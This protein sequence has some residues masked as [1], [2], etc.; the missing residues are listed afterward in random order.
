MFKK[1]SESLLRNAWAHLSRDSPIPAQQLPEKTS[2][3]WHMKLSN[4]RGLSTTTQEPVTIG[5]MAAVMF[6]PSVVCGYLA[7]WQYERMEWKES[8]IKVRSDSLQNEARNIFN[9]GDPKEYEKVS[10]CGVF[11]H[12]KSVFVGPRP[13]NVPGIGIQ[14]GYLLITPLYD[15]KRKGAILVNRGWVPRSWEKD[16]RLL[17][18]S[19]KG[20]AEIVGVVQP[21][22]KPSAVVPDNV[23]EKGEFHWLDVPN[24][25]RA[26]GLP[27]D[28]PLV[29]AVSNDP[30]TVQQMKRQSPLEESRDRPL[31]DNTTPTFPIP[32]NA[33]DLVRFST[34]PSDHMMYAATWAM[35][36]VGLG[37]MARQVVFYPRKYRKMIGHTNKEHWKSVSTSD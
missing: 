3:L 22:E 11:L 14:S 37:V 31:A 2:R 30:A 27:L 5:P 1:L 8:L 34:M 16:I 32:K 9:H 36:C 20:E 13:R 12:D 24:L 17:Q 28:T 35:L 23:L 10:A 15:A 7:Y 6:I 26:C 33:Q 21:S 25:A 4:I 19:S 18:Q 29:Q